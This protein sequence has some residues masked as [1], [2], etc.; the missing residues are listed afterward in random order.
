MNAKPAREPA[1]MPE[2]IRQKM[3]ARAPVRQLS[4][5]LRRGAF[6]VGAAHRPQHQNRTHS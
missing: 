3:A 1:I 2:G 5:A 6:F 4:P